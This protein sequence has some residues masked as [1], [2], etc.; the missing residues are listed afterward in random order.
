MGTSHEEQNT[1]LSYLAEFFSDWGLF[2]KKLKKNRN[3]HFMFNTSFRKS[4]SLWDNVEKRCTT[5]Q[6]TD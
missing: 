4:C 5:G 3:T 6:A 2:Q 1:F